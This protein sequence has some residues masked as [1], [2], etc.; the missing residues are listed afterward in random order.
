MSFA[1]NLDT[2]LTKMN[3][4]VDAGQNALEVFE[5]ASDVMGKL[6]QFG[7]VLGVLSVA[8][9]IAKMF[10][11]EPS[12]EDIIIEK[13]DN[14]NERITLLTE[15]ISDKFEEN[16]LWNTQKK[17]KGL[18]D[19]EISLLE[20]DFYK[21]P[22]PSNK[23]VGEVAE[24][25]SANKKV[26][27][28]YRRTLPAGQSGDDLKD[29]FWDTYD[30]ID[31]ITTLPASQRAVIKQ[32]KNLVTLIEPFNEYQ[33]NVTNR[34][35]LLV[36]WITQDPTS[37]DGNLFDAIYQFTNGNAS[38][39]L[40][41]G[42]KVF[43]AVFE[44]G[45]AVNTIRQ[46]QHKL[47]PNFDYEV[48]VHDEKIGDVPEFK[49]ALESIQHAITE[50]VERCKNEFP[51]NVKARAKKLFKELK[52]TKDMEDYAKP[53]NELAEKLGANYNWQHFHVVIYDPVSGGDV[54]KYLSPATPGSGDYRRTS[55]GAEHWWSEPLGSSDQ[56]F[57]VII[58]WKKI[59]QGYV[60]PFGNSDFA[61]AADD[62]YLTILKGLRYVAADS[63]RDLVE[64]PYAPDFRDPVK[65][66]KEGDAS[67]SYTYSALGRSYLNLIASNIRL[68]FNGA[69][70]PYWI[71]MDPK[72][73]DNQG[74]HK[75]GFGTS[76]VLNFYIYTRNSVARFPNGHPVLFSESPWKEVTKRVVPSQAPLM[77]FFD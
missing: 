62:L 21:L 15:K 6:S 56:E 2:S 34:I 61:K 69:N 32:A 43:N 73:T 10:T 45:K 36:K 3:D 27:D 28:E 76:S 8:M 66:F 44:T 74:G 75:F 1:E 17:I 50:A 49:A 24:F 64:N 40:E 14:L 71:L 19:H 20:S 51:S 4:A 46:I 22:T 48:T 63:L 16:Q 68:K 59:E 5:K 18:V 29:Y 26:N 55:Q 9:D 67:A 25:I 11:G 42:L 31:D 60:S 70:F 47:D 53:A 38:D 65:K 54:H 77:I 58:F 39:I 41:Y 30:T 33:K 72:D 37:G 35:D 52:I 23:T 57:N 13:I 7:A 12:A